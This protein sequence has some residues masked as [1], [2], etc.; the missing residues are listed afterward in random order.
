MK[1]LPSKLP[2]ETVV[3][4]IVNIAILVANGVK[5]VIEV[6]KKKRKRKNS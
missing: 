6:F 1:M 3:I 4:G 2:S 5:S